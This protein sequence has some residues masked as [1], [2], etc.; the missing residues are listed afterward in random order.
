M[1]LKEERE[2]RIELRAK[3][4]REHEATRMALGKN[5]FW[6]T[7]KEVFTVF[8]CL[9]F[10]LALAWVA[11]GCAIRLA[12]NLADIGLATFVIYYCWFIHRRD[13]A[14]HKFLETK[15]QK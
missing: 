6:L 3:I 4:Q 13:T 8:T 10:F 7:Y 12:R 15:R 11:S 14:R 2:S 1:P 5:K 9:M